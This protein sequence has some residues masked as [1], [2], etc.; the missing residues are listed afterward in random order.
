MTLST[1]GATLLVVHSTCGRGSPPVGRAGGG[2][3]ATKEQ[4]QQSKQQMSVA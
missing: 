1:I 2:V 3:T 4:L